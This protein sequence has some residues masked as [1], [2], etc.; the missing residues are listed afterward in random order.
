MGPSTS[1]SITP[2]SSA[3]RRW[4]T[5]PAETWRELMRTNLDSVFFVGQAVAGHMIAR[6]RGKIINICSVQSEL[7]RPLDRALR[8]EQG[9]GENADQ[10]YVR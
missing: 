3:E 4:R 10:G 6:K 9:G 8:G 5:F 2:E 1:L 7:G